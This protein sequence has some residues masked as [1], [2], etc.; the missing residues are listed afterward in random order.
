MGGPVWHASGRGRSV[1]ES[2]RL[3]LLALEGVG[4]RAIADR[5]F[6]G[7]RG[8]VHVQRRLAQAELDLAGITGLVDIRGTRRESELLVEVLIE[9]G[10]VSPTSVGSV[11]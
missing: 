6:E 1:S 5:E 2:R 10:S 9:R 7:S 8:I 4:D 3:A 11:R